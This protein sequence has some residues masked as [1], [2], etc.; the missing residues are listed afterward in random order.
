MADSNGPDFAVYTVIE[1]E[2]GKDP[3]W[4]RIGAAWAHKDGNGYNVTLDALPV[5]G[6]ISLRKPQAE[7]DE[8]EK[9]AKKK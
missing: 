1:R 2:K 7:D 6:R 3:F 4:L 5:N 9:P 8:P